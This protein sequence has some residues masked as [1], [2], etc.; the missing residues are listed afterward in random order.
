MPLPKLPHVAYLRSR[1]A[2][3]AET[4]LLCTIPISPFRRRERKAVVEQ[5]LVSHVVLQTGSTLPKAAV[6]QWPQAHTVA[7]A[8]GH[9][10]RPRMARKGFEL[11][12]LGCVPY[13]TVGTWTKAV[14]V[15][16]STTACRRL[17]AGTARLWKG[18]TT[19]LQV[20]ES[21]GLIV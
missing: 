18:T 16:W 4:A 7:N 8:A 5:L 17:D 2:A 19:S 21:E 1:V 11:Q 3:V 12:R 13:A 14:L 20:Y 10:V 9:T 15:G 6:M